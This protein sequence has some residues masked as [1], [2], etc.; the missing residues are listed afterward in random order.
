[1][2]KFAFVLS[3]SALALTGCVSQD[4]AD[5]K[6]AKGCAAGVGALLTEPKE[7]IV[8]KT[9]NFSNEET[10]EGLHRRVTLEATE[11]DGWVEMDKSYT[12]LFAQEWGFFKSSHRALLVQVKIGEEIYGKRDG[13]ILGGFED[14]LKLTETVDGAMAQ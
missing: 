1:M 5:A 8:V 4:Q 2:K 3:L 13:E 11:K 7:I 12:C 14:F 6:M 10:S 9:E